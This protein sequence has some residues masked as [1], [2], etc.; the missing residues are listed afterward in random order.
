MLREH[1]SQAQDAASRRAEIIDAHI[2][3]IEGQLTRRPSRI[4]DLG[5]GP[6][7]YTNRLARLGHECTGID[8]SPASIAF[9]REQVEREHLNC[10]YIEADIR[11][12]EIEETFDLVMLISGEL[13]VFSPPSARTV[14]NNARR[15]L[16]PEGLL[17]LEV[18]PYDV[19]REKGSR[20]RSWYDTTS[21]V[22]SDAPHVCLQEQVWHHDAH[23]VAIRYVI[24][25]AASGDVSIYGQSF[26][27][28]TSG[29]FDELLEE[30]GFDE[31]KRF[32]SLSGRDVD[33][34]FEVLVART[35]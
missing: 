35:R 16:S 30:C 32:A 31:P 33:P 24:V 25:D 27:A 8:Y 15:A 1:L 14:L 13:N 10:T 34:Q 7:L 29:E 12:A 11:L 18:H 22:F 17:I 9:A 26:Q 20:G 2:R 21:D 28:Y 5:C 6:G 4:L 3:W 23:A 19:I